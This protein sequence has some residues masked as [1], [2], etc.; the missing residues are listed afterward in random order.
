MNVEVLIL[1]KGCIAVEL[2]NIYY[3]IFPLHSHTVKNC[4]P[5]V[6]GLEDMVHQLNTTNNFSKFVRSMR[7]SF[8]ETVKAPNN[9]NP[10]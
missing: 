5:K 4:M 9:T 10:C 1:M 2:V 6:Q 3:T 8:K 7:K